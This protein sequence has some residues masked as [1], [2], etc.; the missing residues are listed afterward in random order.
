MLPHPAVSLTAA[1]PHCVTCRVSPEEAREGPRPA[2][3][4]V[5]G[6]ATAT[7]LAVAVVPPAALQEG[8]AGLEMA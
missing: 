3:R 2:S 7:E 5:M 4:A 1:A 6:K 8:R